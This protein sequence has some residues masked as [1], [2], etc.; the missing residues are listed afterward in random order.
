MTK[1]CNIVRD[2]YT[3]SPESYNTLPAISMAIFQTY[4]YKTGNIPNITGMILTNIRK[5][6][7][8][9]IVD[10]FKP[11]I[12]G[13]F[14]Y[15]VNSLYPYAMLQD[16]PVGVPVYT[17]E[18]NLDKVFGF[19]H[20]RITTPV[21]M[22]MPTLPYNDSGRLLSPCGTWRGWYFS[23]ELKD[24]RRHGYKIEILG[25]YTFQRGENIFKT[26]VMHFYNIKAS[27]DTELKLVAKLVLNSLY[28][29]FGAQE[30]TENTKIMTSMETD[31]LFTTHDIS[32]IEPLLGDGDKELVTYD[33]IPN[34]EKCDKVGVSYEKLLLELDT[35]GYKNNYIS[36]AIASAVTAYARIHMNRLKRLPGITVCYT[37]TDSL[38]TTTPLDPE[39]VGKDIGLMKLE[40][41]IREGIFIAP[42][43]Y[44]IE[45]T[46]K[47][48]SK[49]KGVGNLLAKDDFL[50]LLS[51]EDVFVE[52]TKTY[53]I[54]DI[55]KGSVNIL[56]RKITTSNNF[57]KRTKV[58]SADGT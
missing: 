9:D 45:G 37:D 35:H 51:G 31:T 21:G 54:R 11:H 5:S 18:K 23:E 25:G 19:F 56:D 40:T 17:Q 27:D 55:P 16:M 1:F 52:T 7:Y 36:I 30:Y 22:N 41:E 38:V 2:R 14:L 13:G 33:I 58:F 20:A 12:F 6:Y 53:W 47:N 57:L 3:V 43:V 49:T 48:V 26:F 10:V 24:A 15:D 44:Y 39:Y 29:K 4:F 34:R 46:D 8:S 50:K 32:S 28:G 42:K